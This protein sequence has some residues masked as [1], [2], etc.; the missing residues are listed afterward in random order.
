MKFQ[1][2]TQNSFKQRQEQSFRLIERYEK[3]IPI[4]LE[5]YIQDAEKKQIP[6][7]D[8]QIKKILV[9]EQI[10]VQQ[11]FDKFNQRFSQYIGK[12]ESLF[13]FYGGNKLITNSFSQTIQK[14]YQQEK[15]IDDW[16][17][18]ELRIQETSG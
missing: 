7:A 12:K 3:M 4:I 9:H 16:L 14:L 2:K 10:S 13:L 11:I 5:I 18:L 15:D 8:L 6:K 17:Y 1:F